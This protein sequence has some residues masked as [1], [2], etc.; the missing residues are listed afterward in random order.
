MGAA[1]IGGVAVG[2]FD[3]FDVI[4]RFVRVEHTAVPDAE[5]QKVYCK[6]MPVFEKAYR[7][8]VGVYRGPGR[9][10]SKRLRGEF[11]ESSCGY[12][13]REKCGLSN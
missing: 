13:S 3:G 6:L 1:V 9:L 2:L 12:S 8:L 5:Q 11:D 7:S 10:A 4:D